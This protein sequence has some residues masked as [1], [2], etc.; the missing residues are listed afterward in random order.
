[1]GKRKNRKTR[2]NKKKRKNRK[3][4]TRKWLKEK[5]SPKSGLEKLKFCDLLI[6]VISRVIWNHQV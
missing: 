1:M 3:N 4:R 5:C 6:Y 2:T